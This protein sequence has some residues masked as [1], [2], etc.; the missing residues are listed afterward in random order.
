MNTFQDNGGIFS[1]GCTIIVYPKNKFYYGIH[2]TTQQENTEHRNHERKNN[3][4]GD[5][6][7]K[8]GKNK[9]QD[10]CHTSDS[11]R[12]TCFRECELFSVNL[13]GCGKKD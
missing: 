10:I 8:Q 6:N 4:W 9:N 13:V 2:T 3:V 12:N 7:K 5:Q 11:H 1:Y